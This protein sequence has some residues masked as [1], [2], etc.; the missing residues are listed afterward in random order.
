MVINRPRDWVDTESMLSSEI[1]IDAPEGRTGRD[2]WLETPTSATTALHW[3]SPAADGGT[4]SGRQRA[5]IAV[6]PRHASHLVRLESS[7]ARLVV[8]EIQPRR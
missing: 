4:N 3:S 6:G 5:A 2:V 7:A 8:A 1:D